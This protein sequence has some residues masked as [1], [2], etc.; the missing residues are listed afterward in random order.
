[1]AEKENR[2]L[3]ML[4]FTNWTSTLEEALRKKK[5]EEN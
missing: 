3:V 5:E 4:C 1:M 2:N